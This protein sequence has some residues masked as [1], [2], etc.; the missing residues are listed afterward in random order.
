MLGLAGRQH[1][2]LMVVGYAHP[3]QSSHYQQCLERGDEQGLS[4][5][6]PT[7]GQESEGAAGVHAAWLHGRAE[8]QPPTHA[9]ETALGSPSWLAGQR[10]IA[11]LQPT[12]S[13]LE[14]SQD[15]C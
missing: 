11:S 12:C 10:D 13:A 4:H 2:H 3:D 5:I 14:R 9:G 15:R 8:G 6:S 7:S 1:G